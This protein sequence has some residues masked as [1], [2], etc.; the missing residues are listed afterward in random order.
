MEK[1][2][3]ILI[4]HGHLGKWHAEKIQKIE[5]ADL[6]GVVDANEETRKEVSKKYPQTQVYSTLDEVSEDSFDAAV[7]AAPTSFHF[8]I[9]Q[10]LLISDKHIFCEKPVTT[11][12]NE[13]REL[14]NLWNEKTVFQVGHSERFHEFWQKQE[15]YNPFLTENAFFV[16]SRQA[17][18]NNRATDVDVVQDLMI[19]DLDLL[20]FLLNKPTLKNVKAWGEKIR[21]SFKD[22]VVAELEFEEGF[23]ALIRSGRNYPHVERY[24]DIN[25]FKGCLR[26]DLLTEVLKIQR[27]QSFEVESYDFKKRDHLYE[28][29]EMFYN[30]IIHS[31]SPWVDLK[32]ASEV[33]KWVDRVRDELGEL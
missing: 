21:S 33:M 32:E 26:F 24:L 8:E 19:H 12:S 17:P 9:C 15:L 16:A 23:R 30:S 25:S 22:Q 2:R 13:T 5:L 4:G 10:K 1:I 29:H 6:I 7:I 18:F 31:L 14:L 11:S 3:T 28:E 27:N 20:Y